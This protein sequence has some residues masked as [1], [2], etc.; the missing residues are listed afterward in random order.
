LRTVR[1]ILLCVRR[2][3]L[4]K[5]VE[6]TD[7]IL[8]SALVFISSVSPAARSLQ[9]SPA[10]VCDWLLRVAARRRQ[11]WSHAA[12]TAAAAA[13]ERPRPLRSVVTDPWIARRSRR[14]DRHRGAAR[15]S[16]RTRCGR[17]RVLWRTGGRPPVWRQP[18][19]KQNTA[20]TAGRVGCKWAGHSFIHYRWTRGSS[21]RFVSA[22]L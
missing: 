8:C 12:S 13:L 20:P 4:R 21:R 7:T 14:A 10:I 18:S 22:T 15:T 3:K 5:S 6:R 1:N 19:Q 11:R 2:S 9:E 16:R 17:S